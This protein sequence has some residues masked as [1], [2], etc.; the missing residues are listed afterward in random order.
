MNEARVFFGN[1]MILTLQAIGDR[2]G[3]KSLKERFETTFGAETVLD[4]EAAGVMVG[5][6]ME[7][8]WIAE[9]FFKD[10]LA[11][12]ESV[13]QTRNEYYQCVQ[14]FFESYEQFVSV[15]ENRTHEK[16]EQARKQLDE[17]LQPFVDR[18]RE[19]TVS[20]FLEAATK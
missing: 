1:N 13:Q 11:F 7:F 15:R 3:S 4:K 19:Q 18:L 12:K 9:H 10:Y 5:Q 14:G 8:Y 20:L 17:S 2:G 16:V 6:D